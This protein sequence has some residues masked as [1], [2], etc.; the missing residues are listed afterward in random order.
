M[1]RLQGFTLIEL[2][3]VV[4]IIAILA[5]IAVPNFLEAQVRSKVS[6]AKA[7]LR[8]VAVAIE[9][10]NVDHNRP[11]REMHS[12]YG[13]TI[14]SVAVNGIVWPGGIM[15]LAPANRFMA[16]LSTPIAYI[17]KAHL[18]D[19]FVLQGENLPEDEK[20]F[21]YQNL[22]VRSLPAST[23]PPHPTFSAT[24]SAAAL[25]FYGVWRMCC[26]GPDRLFSN[27]MTGSGGVVNRAQ[28]EYDATNGT[29]S[30]GNLWRSQKRQFEQPLVG[31][32]LGAH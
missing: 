6:R 19:P 13:D 27:D 14:G 32:L 10:Y 29:V 20:T 25:D 28:M 18:T 4:A 30:E 22:L 12:S 26:I 31:P 16:G 7:D 5:A 15:P 9:S 17:T 23:S 1:K 8:S 24:F 21:T 3:I 11:P 2:L